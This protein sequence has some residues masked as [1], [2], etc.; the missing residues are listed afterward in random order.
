MS[1]LL[2]ASVCFYGEVMTVA[3][4]LVMSVSGAVSGAYAEMVAGNVGLG[5]G[6][7]SMAFL[8]SVGNAGVICYCCLL[9]P[10]ASPVS[11]RHIPPLPLL[12][13][14]SRPDRKRDENR[15]DRKRDRDQSHKHP[16]RCFHCWQ[17][18]HKNVDGAG[19][20]CTN[21]E[22]PP[23]SAARKARDDTIARVKN[24]RRD[25]RTRQ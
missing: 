12:P 24:K 17:L 6:A 9:W 13:D 10:L 19:R 11:P 5:M 20:A 15:P 8:E 7:L 23:G 18:G 3:L 1:S 22:P 14:P 25:K 21:P 16:V 2:D 4:L